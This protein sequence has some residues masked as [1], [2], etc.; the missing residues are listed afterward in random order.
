MTTIKT[1]K[2][3]PYYKAKS[4]LLW[5]AIIVFISTVGRQSPVNRGRDNVR[6][7]K[8]THIMENT[9]EMEIKIGAA[10]ASSAVRTL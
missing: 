6:Y 3:P 10:P 9:L 7:Y 1:V 8:I 2:P 5:V 4:L